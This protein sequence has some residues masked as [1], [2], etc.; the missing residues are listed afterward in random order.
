MTF[1]PA[2]A[3]Y[4][5]GFNPTNLVVVGTKSSR[6]SETPIVVYSNEYKGKT[7]FHIRE[8]W[9]DQNDCWNVGK[10]LSIPNDQAASVFAAIG[11]LV[12]PVAAPAAKASP[13]KVKTA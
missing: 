8:L 12:T 10:G 13:R 6:G 9:C 5:Q 7:Y 3:D 2:T 1:N 11:K 4:A